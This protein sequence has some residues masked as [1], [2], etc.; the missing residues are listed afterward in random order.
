MEQVRAWYNLASLKILAVASVSFKCQW[1]QEKESTGYVNICV[2]KD[3]Y[4]STGFSVTVETL[5]GTAQGE[6]IGDG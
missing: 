1:L 5:P 4:T 2:Q 3:S 6:E